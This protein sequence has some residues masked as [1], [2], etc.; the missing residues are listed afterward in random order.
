MI[1]TNQPNARTILG[2]VELKWNDTRFVRPS[3][4]EKPPLI[5]TLLTSNT[6]KLKITN[7]DL[8]GQYFWLTTSQETLINSLAITTGEFTLNGEE[9]EYEIDIPLVDFLYA[10]NTEYYF[11]MRK[12]GGDEKIQIRFITGQNLVKA[13]G[14]DIINTLPGGSITTSGQEL[15]TS[16]NRIVD[17]KSRAENLSEVSTDLQWVSAKYL[18]EKFQAID[19]EIE[20]L[21]IEI[22]DQ[23]GTISDLSG[24]IDGVNTIYTVSQEI[25]E[26]IKAVYLNGQLLQ[27]TT[28]WGELDPTTGTF[29][30][31]TAP[32]AGS[33]LTVKYNT[34]AALGLNISFDSLSNDFK[35][36][37]EATR[38]GVI[39][40]EGQTAFLEPSINTLDNTKIDLPPM[41]YVVFYLDENKKI[42]KK[43]K[44]WEGQT[45][46]NL[47]FQVGDTST[48]N[49]I[50][51]VYYDVLT[52]DLAV[53]LTYNYAE[54]AQTPEKAEQLVM[55][56]PITRNPANGQVTIINI[57]YPGGIKNGSNE[58][59]IKK[60]LNN[61]VVFAGGKI[62]ITQTPD[63]GNVGT[64]IT[65][66]SVSA[67]TFGRGRGNNDYL[68]TDV[69]TLTGQNL[70]GGGSGI[71]TA[72]FG[73][74]LAG[75]NEGGL[76][77]R[78]SGANA[79]LRFDAFNRGFPVFESGMA[80]AFNQTNF[81]QLS[82]VSS[83]ALYGIL[84]YATKTD[85]GIT[86]VVAIVCGNVSIANNNAIIT[87]NTITSTDTANIDGK[88][89]T[90]RIIQTFLAG[91]MAIQIGY[92]SDLLPNSATNLNKIKC[93]NKN[94][95]F[96]SNIY[97]LF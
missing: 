94:R 88:L 38:T 78:I 58:E 61:P 57:V 25:Y 2:T 86:T 23:T 27:K 40:E 51:W 14:T 4:K 77:N 63:G 54:I 46:L 72:L 13:T 74:G 69:I 66:E 48:T 37:N 19:T 96:V 76:F 7:L 3:A 59:K 42:V 70:I 21:P 5:G 18:Y 15:N 93:W 82:A 91:Y 31:L 20:N 81:P 87:T 26:S 60:I 44:N 83:W 24:Q 92:N 8:L 56:A 45:A 39:F 33:V 75:L 73:S 67:D 52:D 50:V 9:N 1:T 85:A 97:N 28:Q 80:T 62:A 79:R 32:P 53:H 41:R 68:N 17:E 11:G 84:R 16:N 71:Q 30:I 90:D 95:T 47:N 65:L 89:K 64:Y 49:R 36:I 34:N 29:E 10:P 43:I 55:V 12:V 22:I 35:I 6:L